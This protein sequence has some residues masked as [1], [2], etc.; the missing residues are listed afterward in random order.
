MEWVCQEFS[1]SVVELLS[2]FDYLN[3]FSTFIIPEILSFN[4]QFP[5]QGL[6]ACKFCVKTPKRCFFLYSVNGKIYPVRLVV[7]HLILFTSAIISGCM[8]IQKARDAINTAVLPVGICCSFWFPFPLTGLLL[9]DLVCVQPLWLL[10][11]LS[12]AVERDL[13]GK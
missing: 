3:I 12:E 4:L 10:A 2:I 7:A 1:Q 8:P 5:D 6:Q 9:W 13:K 11:E